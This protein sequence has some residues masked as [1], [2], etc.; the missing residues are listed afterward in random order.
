MPALLAYLVALT[1]LL[2]TGYG[3]LHYLSQP[4]SS[5]LTQSQQAKLAARKKFEREAAIRQSKED[6]PE[7]AATMQSATAP[8]LPPVRDVA[9]LP[10]PKVKEIAPTASAPV[11]AAA[12][13]PAI[14]AP[15]AS[16]APVENNAAEATAVEAKPAVVAAKNPA[17]AMAA[18]PEPAAAPP[19]ATSPPT[20]AATAENS[21]P[22]NP[23]IAPPAAKRKATKPARKIA[24]LRPRN[25]P[26]MMTLQT[27]EYPDGRIGQRLV[28]WNAP[29]RRTMMT[30]RMSGGWFGEHD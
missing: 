7:G 28:P 1:V 12:P 14:A 27:V 9:A 11:A 18:I 24:K 4:D 21:E 16:L 17:D 3:G 15:A 2:G 23:E 6:A 10:A 19:T 30:T 29:Q 20:P 8:P 13:A 25:K 5:A 22:A 26:V